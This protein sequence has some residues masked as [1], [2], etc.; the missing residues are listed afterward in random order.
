M[1]EPLVAYIVLPPVSSLKQSYRCST[2]LK[3]EMLSRFN[4]LDPRHPKGIRKCV[5]ETAAATELSSYQVELTPRTICIGALHQGLCLLLRW[6]R[7]QR[8]ENVCRVMAVK[9]LIRAK[10]C[11]FFR[12]IVEYQDRS[13]TRRTIMIR[14]ST[15]S[16][17]AEVHP[18]CK[19]LRET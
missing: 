3:H 17:G 15:C 4:R 9:S 14:S 7:L 11:E 1:T 10:G 18:N 16:L 8:R 19:L 2:V 6:R 5:L 12:L 13:L